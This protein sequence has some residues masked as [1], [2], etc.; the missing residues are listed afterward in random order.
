MTKEEVEMNAKFGAKIRDARIKVGLT[1]NQ[2][3]EL[4]GCS[5]VAIMRYE[6]GQRKMNLTLI[7]SVAEKLNIT[8]YDLMGPEYWDALAGPEKLSEIRTGVAN[9][10]AVEAMFGEKAAELI[11]HFTGLNDLGQAKAIDYVC[12]LAE[13]SKYQK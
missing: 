9:L 10:E 1:Q 6:K 4:I 5:G 3:G 7:E 12:D 11:G 2:L 8:P 13:Q